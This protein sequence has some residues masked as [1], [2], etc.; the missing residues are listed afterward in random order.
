MKQSRTL[1]VLIVWLALLNNAAFSQTF[2]TT[3]EAKRYFYNLDDGFNKAMTTK[4]S[5]FFLDHFS[6]GFINETPYGILNNKKAEAKGLVGLAPAHVVRVAPQ[7][8]IFTYSCEV[9]ALCVTKKLTM[10]DSTVLY[11]R[12]TIVHKLI[13]G[14]WKIVSG[15]GTVLQPAIAEGK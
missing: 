3:E 6:D 4:D 13:N 10:R 5:S 2:A 1:P 12:R 9:A 8:D 15:Q 7:Y 14:K 11:V